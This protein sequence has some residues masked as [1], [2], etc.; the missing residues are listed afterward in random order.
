[1][2]KFSSPIANG[3]GSVEV[4]GQEDAGMTTPSFRSVLVLFR[5]PVSISDDWHWLA[6]CLPSS[7]EF[8]FS[9]TVLLARGRPGAFG[10]STLSRSS[11][12]TLAGSEG[13]TMLYKIIIK[14]TDGHSYTL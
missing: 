6:I 1:M 3:W 4:E 2:P 8:E 7:D 14:I 11:G 10:R 12:S 13:T 5:V 9:R